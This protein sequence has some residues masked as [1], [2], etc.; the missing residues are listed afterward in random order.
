MFALA[1]GLDLFLV[2]FPISMID[3]RRESEKLEEMP[4][5]T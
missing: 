5:F 2:A 3:F 1:R 4:S